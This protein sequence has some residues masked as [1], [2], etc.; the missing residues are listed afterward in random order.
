MTIYWFVKKGQGVMNMGAT[1]FVYDKKRTAEDARLKLKKKYQGVSE[2]NISPIH[3]EEKGL[4]FLA[5]DDWSESDPGF[6]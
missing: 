4:S 5:P 6:W 3:E 1:I 2:E